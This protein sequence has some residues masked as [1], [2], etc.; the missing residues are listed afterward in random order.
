MSKK[1]EV[2]PGTYDEVYLDY[3]PDP[4]TLPPTDDPNELEWRNRMPLAE[5]L[6]SVVVVNT[7]EKGT[8]VYR[9]TITGS[10]YLVLD[11]LTNA[12]R[13]SMRQAALWER[14]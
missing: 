7:P 12:I 6:G 8:L 13:V 5:S 1:I 10:A 9:E 3:A 4:E 11:T 14:E 2:P